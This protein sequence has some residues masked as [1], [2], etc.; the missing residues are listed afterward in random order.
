M[1]RVCAQSLSHVQLF[2]TPRTVAHQAPLSMGFFQTRY[3]SGLSFPPSGDLPHPGTEPVSPMQLLHW[4]ADSLPLHHLGSASLGHRGEGANV[5]L[6]GGSWALSE[7]VGLTWVLGSASTMPHFHSGCV[8]GSES[9]A[10]FVFVHFL[11]RLVW[12]LKTAGQGYIMLSFE[13]YTLNCSES[14]SPP[15][16]FNFMV[17]SS[18]V[19]RTSQGALFTDFSVNGDP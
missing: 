17:C 16:C 1:T 2:A 9:P 8:L 15:T 19:L 11:L 12:I 14:K 10:H 5:G 4:L 3:W 13:K 7:D 18:S 6:A